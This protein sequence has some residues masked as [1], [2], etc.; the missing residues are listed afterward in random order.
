MALSSP[1]QSVRNNR[2]RSSRQCPALYVEGRDIDGADDPPVDK[3][4]QGFQALRKLFLSVKFSEK[5]AQAVQKRLQ[6]SKI[7]NINGTTTKWEETRL[8]VA[9]H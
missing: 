5:D 8:H 4:T 2:R 9:T 6:N 7:R 1:S 3:S